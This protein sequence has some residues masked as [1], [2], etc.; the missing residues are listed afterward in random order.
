MHLNAEWILRRVVQDYVPVSCSSRR[1][2]FIE[3]IANSFRGV[4]S[5]VAGSVVNS[6][7]FHLFILVAGSDNRHS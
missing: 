2:F 7:I 1:C 6:G 4:Q 5:E 3:Y